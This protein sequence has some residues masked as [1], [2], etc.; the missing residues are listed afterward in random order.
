MFYTMSEIKHEVIFRRVRQVAEPGAKSAVSHYILLSSA[1]SSSRAFW[2][3]S[4]PLKLES[5]LRCMQQKNYSVLNNGIA[6]RLL[7]PTAM[8]LISRCHVSLP[9]EKSAPAMQ[10]FVKIL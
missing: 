9:R 7:Q 4:G 5:L 10:P 1:E 3:L 6:A 2:G 8:L